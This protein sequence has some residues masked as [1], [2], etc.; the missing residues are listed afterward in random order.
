MIQRIQSLYLLLA[1]I[2]LGALFFPA[3]F[4]DLNP[5]SAIER[6]Q[7]LADNTLNLED[8]NLSMIST[9]AGIALFLA[10]IFLFKNRRLQT[11]IVAVSML[12]A[13]LVFLGAAWL[14]MDN[15]KL[16]GNDLAPGLGLGS[17]VIAILF[18]WLANRAIRKDENLVRSMDRLR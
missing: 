7:A 18:G 8:S 16:A 3:S 14:F 10:A 4:G 17:P 1:V 2:A 9:F 6:S 5:G 15:S 11:R 12:A 13:L